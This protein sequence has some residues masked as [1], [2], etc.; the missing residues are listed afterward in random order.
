MQIV[1]IEYLVAF[2]VCLVF[3]F[4]PFSKQA[5]SIVLFVDNCLIFVDTYCVCLAALVKGLFG[6]C[7]NQCAKFFCSDRPIYLLILTFWGWWLPDMLCYF[8][9]C[10]NLPNALY[11]FYYTTKI[12][13][14]ISFLPILCTVYIC[15][16]SAIL[17]SLSLKISL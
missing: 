10:P 16:I 7:V 13:V 1:C 5:C 11:N 14:Y 17:I 3:I 12:W 8:V 15:I 6:E 4:W 9:I 2:S